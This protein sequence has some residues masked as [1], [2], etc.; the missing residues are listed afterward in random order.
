MAARLEQF[1]ERLNLASD[2][3]RREVVHRFE[4]HVD[5]DPSF[6]SQG[7]FNLHRHPRLHRA[8]AFVE[9]VDVDFEK[10]SLSYGWQR[11]DRLP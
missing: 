11:L 6:A 9:V 5:P 10:F 1:R 7:V 3:R 4:G 2:G 8:K